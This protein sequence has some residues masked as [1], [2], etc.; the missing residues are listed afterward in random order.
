MKP[1]FKCEY[2]FY[3]NSHHLSQIYDGFEKLKKQG[4]VNLVLNKDSGTNTTAFL[5]VLVNDKI[6]VIY[7]TQDG[8]NWIKGKIEDGQLEESP[9]TAK[10]INTIS[11]TFISVLKGIYHERIEYPEKS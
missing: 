3:S 2:T 5:E 1:L 6:K 11:E 4:I 8:L 9:I 7:D 10:E